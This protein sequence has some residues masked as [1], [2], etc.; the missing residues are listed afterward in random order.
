[1]PNE[2]QASL[3][4]MSPQDAQ[5]ALQQQDQAQAHAFA[6]QMGPQGNPYYSP[7]IGSLF[8]QAG[9]ATGRAMQ[10][11]FGVVPPEV[12]KAYT[13]QEVMQEVDSQGIEFDQ[14]PVGYM[15]LAASSMLKRGLRDEAMQ[16]IQQAQAYRSTEADMGYKGAMGEQAQAVAQEKRDT[17]DEKQALMTAQAELANARAG[18]ARIDAEI[19]QLEEARANAREPK[20]IELIDAKIKNLTN[21]GQAALTAAAKRV[22]SLSKESLGQL[23]AR[24]LTEDYESGAIDRAEYQ[25][26]T[27]QLLVNPMNLLMGDMMNKG[28]LGG[29]PAPTNPR[30]PASAPKPQAQSPAPQAKQPA[31][32]E[33][34]KQGN[35]EYNA[36]AAW[37]SYNPN[38]YVYGINPK[39]GKFARAPK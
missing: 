12:Q 16:A 24:Q 20:E 14:D 37:G 5:Q 10:G 7:A 9:A 25:R 29:M 31:I 3:F 17:L 39:T 23:A 6:N 26:R 21:M 30:A 1:M 18:K 8:G 33:K 13:M 4:G 22:G 19:A 34:T 11:A 27:A 15:K 36:L 35:D 2:Q 28:E 32:S 38:K